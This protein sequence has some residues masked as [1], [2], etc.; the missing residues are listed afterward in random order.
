MAALPQSFAV[1]KRDFMGTH[2]TWNAVNPHA[3]G[4]RYYAMYELAK[5]T[6]SVK[7]F[8]DAFQGGALLGGSW[9]ASGR[10]L[11]LTSILCGGPY[12]CGL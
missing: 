10:L 1:A 9:G 3:A 2:L 4:T 11:W 5:Y 8:C 6:V 7:Q 12:R